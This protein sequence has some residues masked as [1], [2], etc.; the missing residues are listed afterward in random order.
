MKERA[1]FL[2]AAC[3][4]IALLGVLPG[5]VVW[6]TG[7]HG[8]FDHLTGYHLFPLLG[9]TAFGLMWSHYIVS[10]MRNLLGLE[11]SVTKPFTV[12]TGWVVLFC[13]VLHPGILVYSLWRD[14]FG[15]PPNSYLEHYVAPS[16][17]WV[18]LLGTVSFFVFLSY[19]LRRWFEG[20]KWWPIIQKANDVAMVL[21]LIHGFKLGGDLQSGWFQLVWLV[22]AETFTAALIFLYYRELKLQNDNMVG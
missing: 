20:K 2:S 5:I 4:L 15:F 22:Y 3:W 6:Y 18:A 10:A 16:L 1:E 9:L 19:E 7:P 8:G 12:V 11:K 17:Q 13:I 21:I 14:G